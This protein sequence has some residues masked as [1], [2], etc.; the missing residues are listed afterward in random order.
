MIF[1]EE[2]PK[3]YKDYLNE[4][5]NE[6][7]E[8]KITITRHEKCITLGKNSDIREVF[9]QKMPI[10][11]SNRG[12][13]ATYHDP[14]QLVLYP[15]INIKKR[16][17]EIRQYINILE[18]W[19]LKALEELGLEASAGSQI[20][21][22]PGIW[23]AGEKVAF[24]GLAVK[25]GLT[26]HGIAFNLEDCLIENFGYIFACRSHE[27]IAKI[28]VSYEKFSKYIQKFKPSVFEKK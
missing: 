1:I 26:Q 8:E 9:E 25:N 17:I 27:K 6:D 19:G 21:K 3:P 11:F 22:M 7:E 13:G 24:I 12:G 15:K 23:L 14:G 20:G 10:Y 28:G 4:L 5:Q 18:N 16:G 2:N